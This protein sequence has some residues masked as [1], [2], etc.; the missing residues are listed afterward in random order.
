MTTSGSDQLEL[1][2]ARDVEE[3]LALRRDVLRP[4]L[5]LDAARFDGDDAPTTRH[6]VAVRDGAIV[7]CASVMAAPEPLRARADLQLRGMAVAERERGRGVG[8]ALLLE[9]HRAVGEPMW[10]NARVAAESLYARAGWVR[11]SDVF[12][13]EGVGPHYRMLFVPSGSDDA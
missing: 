1:R 3:L 7:G 12:E 6:W 4:G 5:A 10:C 2:P 13:I 8:R 9:V 11:T